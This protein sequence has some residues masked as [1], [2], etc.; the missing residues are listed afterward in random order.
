MTLFLAARAAEIPWTPDRDEARR[1]ILQE[2]SQQEYA[3][4]R[5]NPLAEWLE[6]AWHAL[7]GWLTGVEGGAGLPG[8][9]IVAAVIVLTVVLLLW[10]RPRF[11]VPR[12]GDDDRAGVVDAA[13]T[14]EQYREAGDTAIRESRAS[15]A[16]LAY[17]RAILRQGQHRVLLPERAS[18]TATGASATLGE[19]FPEHRA[20]L[21]ESAS[22]FNDVAYGHRG[23]S[24]DQAQ[25][26]AEL[27]RELRAA[28]PSRPSSRHTPRQVVPR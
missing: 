28:S 11:G 5:P 3:E 9:L 16:V 4:Q 7:V 12:S 17:F 15:D 8:W 19:V 23:A 6:A 14:A 25:R 20:R 18:L 1:T 2:L 13:L 26:L 10:L 27:E 22:W 21:D 24:M